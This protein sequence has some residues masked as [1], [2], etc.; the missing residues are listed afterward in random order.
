[1]KV[2]GTI[3]FSLIAIL[4]S[5]VFLLSSLCASATH[6]DDRQIF[7]LV[8]LGALLFVI[9]SMRKIAILNRKPRRV[10]EPDPLLPPYSTVPPSS[11]PPAPPQPS[12]MNSRSIPSSD[13]PRVSQPSVAPP[14]IPPAAS[15][16]RAIRDVVSHLSP[17]SQAAIQQLA[18]AVAAKITAEVALGLVGWYSALGSPR[19]PFALF[20]FGFLA[21]GLAAIA[22]DLALLYSLTRRPGPSTFAYSLVIPALHLLFGISGHSALLVL[23]PRTGQGAIPLLSIIPW[24]LDI[25]VPYLAWKAIRLTGIRPDPTRLI[26]A[27]VVILIYRILLPALF[28]LLN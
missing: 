6:G 17:A 21:W 15:Q 10:P 4:A 19:A 2:L 8:A 11:A 9:A 28:L 14:Y 20:K 24:I 16:P 3:F 13:V 27:F 7:I 12:A 1:M 26:T 25:V 22:P 18:L 23:I 5:L